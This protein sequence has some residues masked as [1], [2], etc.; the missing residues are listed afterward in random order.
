MRARG[1]MPGILY[2]R[3]QYNGRISRDVDIVAGD[4]TLTRYAQTGFQ[5]RNGS[6]CSQVRE[7]VLLRPARIN[8]LNATTPARNECQLMLESFIRNIKKLY[9]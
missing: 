9:A 7:R 8:R 2:S 1:F 5:I 4:L 6:L 3:N